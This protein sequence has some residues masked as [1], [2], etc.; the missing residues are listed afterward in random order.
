VF[1]FSP[2]SSLDS[3]ASA[4]VAGDEHEKKELPTY[5][6]CIV[7]YARNPIAFIPPAL[8]VTFRRRR[9]LPGGSMPEVVSASP[10]CEQEETQHQYRHENVVLSDHDA[11]LSTSLKPKS[12]YLCETNSAVPNGTGRSDG[13][14]MLAKA[15]QPSMSP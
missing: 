10:M 9:L 7:T 2:F 8:S 11:L 12:I 13:N 4:I 6:R 14:H 15:A 1:E 3:A 5:L